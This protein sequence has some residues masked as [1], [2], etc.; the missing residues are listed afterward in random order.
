[1]ALDFPSSPVNGQVYDNFIYDSEKGT[2][3]SISAGSSP[4]YLVGPTITDAVMTATATTPSTVPLTINAAASQSANLQEW[5]NSSG[6]TL[7]YI[8]YTGGL[9][10][11]GITS[12]TSSGLTTFSVGGDSSGQIELGRQDGVAA[13]PYIDFHSGSTVTDFDSRIQGTGGNGTSGNG[14]INITATSV[15]FSGRVTISN[16][17]RFQAYGASG[18]SGTSGQDWIFPGTYVNVGSYYNTSTGRFTSPVSGTYIFFWSNIGN[19]QNT[20]YRYHLRKNGANIDDLHLRLDTGTASYKDNGDR[21][22]LIN[23]AAGDY[24]NI[25]FVSDNATASYTAGQYPWFGGY[26]LA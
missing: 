19:N 23:L 11:K 24:V 10:S 20:V 8:A 14:S 6:I 17:P 13:N 26:L 12:Q 2:W 1:M 9:V 25:Y 3:K 16:Q 5:K 7:S 21:K 15:N 22:A 18:S 4:N